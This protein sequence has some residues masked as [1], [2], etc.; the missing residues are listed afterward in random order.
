MKHVGNVA[1]RELHSLFVSP[2][3]Y[4]VLTLWAVLGSFFFLSAVLSFQDTY[5]I[6]FRKSLLPL[7]HMLLSAGMSNGR[8]EVLLD[9][10]IAPG[11][12][13]GDGSAS[14]SSS[15]RPSRSRRRPDRPRRLRLRPAR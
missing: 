5:L 8:Q 6:Q 14:V 2:V 3:A 9:Q 15:H 4:V 1:I 13:G 11:G 12:S 7:C 10:S